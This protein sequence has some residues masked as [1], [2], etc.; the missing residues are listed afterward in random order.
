MNNGIFGHNLSLIKCMLLLYIVRHIQYIDIYLHHVYNTVHI[1]YT[2]LRYILNNNSSNV[3]SHDV[4]IH[5]QVEIYSVYTYNLM[6]VRVWHSVMVSI[7]AS[8]S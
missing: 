2:T 1:S 6:C 7:Y 8:V 3:K 4:H 5:I